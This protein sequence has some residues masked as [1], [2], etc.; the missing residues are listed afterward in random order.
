MIKNIIFDIGGIIYDDSTQ[1]ISSILK[2]DAIELYKKVYG[3]SFINCILGNQE[4]SD[5]I[6]TV[7][8][9][10]DY[11][12]IKYILN[13]DNLQLSYPLIKDNFNYI[14][15]LKEKGYNLYVLSNITRE[16]YEYMI[17]TIDINKIF[18]GG[19]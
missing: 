3:K 10:K 12:K 14:S 5:Y 9:D 15:K 19:I 2:E 7:K 8:E 16:S 17:N 6:E 13:K 11:E 18:V 1:N 4:V